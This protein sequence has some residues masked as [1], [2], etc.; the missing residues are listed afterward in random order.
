[1]P[2]F[3]PVR[4]YH[5]LRTALLIAKPMWPNSAVSNWST[6]CFGSCSCA[7]FISFITHGWHR[8]APWP[9]IISERVMMFAP[10]T[11]IMIG[12]ACHERPAKLRG[13]RMMP[14]PPRMSITSFD[15]SRPICV[16]WYFAMVEGTAGFSPRATAAAV[17]CDSALIAYA[18]AA[19]RASG[20]S[21]PSKRP[22]DRPNCLRMRA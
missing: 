15:T 6:R 13:P 8:I 1:M 10:S 5:Q 2:I 7:A 20:S 19:M 11:V 18:F 9:K 21:T 17:A 12:A 4:P 14:L 22:T 3:E 16:Q